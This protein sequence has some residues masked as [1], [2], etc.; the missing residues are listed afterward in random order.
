LSGPWYTAENLATRLPQTVATGR[1]DA[2]T[3]TADGGLPA[4]AISVWPYV[5][6]DGGVNYGAG[7]A[8][9]LASQ[10]ITQAAP[11]TLVIS[12][13]ANN[14]FGCQPRALATAKAE[15]CML[16]HGPGRTAAIKAK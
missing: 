12:P 9:N 2:V 5:V 16:C 1:Y 4:L 14:C 6:A 8:Y 11:T 3:P 13:V 7:Y 15:Q 10:V